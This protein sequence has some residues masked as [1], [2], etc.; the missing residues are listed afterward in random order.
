MKKVC[1]TAIGGG[2]DDPKT[3]KRT[4]GWKYVLFTNVPIPKEK[5][6]GWE[7]VL[8]ESELENARFARYCKHNPHKV[9][10][11]YSSDVSIWV[12]AN[13]TVIANLDNILKQLGNFEFITMDHPY[14]NC[15]YQEAL[16]CIKQHKDSADIIN[17]QVIQ[18]KREGMPHG[19]GMI[20]SGILF[21][22]HNNKNVI[23]FQEKWWN[24]V[25]TKSKRDQL[26]FNYV[27]WK[28]PKLI[29]HKM[30]D[31]KQLLFNPNLFP[32][33]PHKHGW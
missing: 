1:Y 26:S 24:E 25:L 28:N 23:E 11:N 30:L 22:K 6:N 20:Q 12:D 14:R 15:I 3:F 31:S 32:I 29:D 19:N 10:E 7:V 16:E 2:Y 21:R 8:I 18:Y 5:H 4:N 17:K 13:L 27:K 33:Q 9:L